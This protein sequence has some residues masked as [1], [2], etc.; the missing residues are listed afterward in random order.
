MS[1]ISGVSVN[2]LTELQRSKIYDLQPDCA[3]KASDVL[4]TVLRLGCGKQLLVEKIPPEAAEGQCLLGRIFLVFLAFTAL[5]PLTLLGLAIA[6]CSGSRSALAKRLQHPKT[7]TPPHSPNPSPPSSPRP[8]PRPSPKKPDPA[9]PVNREAAEFHQLLIDSQKITGRRGDSGFIRQ[10][11]DHLNGYIDRGDIDSLRICLPTKE[12]IPQL[13]VHSIVQKAVLPYAVAHGT[14]AIVGHLIDVF[15]GC[16]SIDELLAGLL[17]QKERASAQKE[18]RM[19]L[20]E[21]ARSSTQADYPMDL[22]AIDGLTERVEAAKKQVA[23]ENEK[24]ERRQKEYEAQQREWE[25]E[26]RELEY[27]RTCH[28]PRGEL[29]YRERS[30]KGYEESIKREEEENSKRWFPVDAA[31][32]ARYSKNQLRKINKEIEVLRSRISSSSTRSS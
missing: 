3:E 28:D 18:V 25:Q 31:E 26:R 11:T 9:P 24:A 32:V 6:A 19:F 16:A 15:P 2:L 12:A 4:L 20:F 22:A 8:S 14:P 27:L 7:P 1:G 29:E 17:A 5:L 30:R 21:R 10:V 23:E 13:A